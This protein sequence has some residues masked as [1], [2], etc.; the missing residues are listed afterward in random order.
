[1]DEIRMVYRLAILIDICH[2]VRQ[3]SNEVVSVRQMVREKV[4]QMAKSRW[5]RSSNRVREVVGSFE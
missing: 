5:E 1:M 3:D 4:R 2:G